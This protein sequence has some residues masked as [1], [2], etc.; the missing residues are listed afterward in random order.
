MSHAVLL[1]AVF[2]LNFMHLI[3]EQTNL[4]ENLYGCYS[5]YRAYSSTVVLINQFISNRRIEFLH[6]TVRQGET[7][8]FSPLCTQGTGK[9]QNQ[10]KKPNL[11]VRIAINK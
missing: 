11:D 3:T 8:L 7:L 4:S 1:Y 2:P 5:R 10:K 6:L 9:K